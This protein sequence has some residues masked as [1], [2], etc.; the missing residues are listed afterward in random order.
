MARAGNE[1]NFYIWD[2]VKH[3]NP[4]YTKPFSKFGGKQ[5]TTID[6]MYQVMC[7]TGRFGPVGKGWR[8][9]NTFNYTDQNVFTLDSSADPLELN[10]VFI[11]LTYLLLSNRPKNTS[12]DTPKYDIAFVKAS[13]A[14]FF[15]A[16]SSS[17]PFFLYKEQT[18][19][20]GPYAYHVSFSFH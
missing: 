10:F 19:D 4:Q 3:T 18:L 15:G 20:I 11:S 13:V 8:F 16:S 1:K 2:E 14:A 5:L 6:P 17:P 12:A 9:K 7:M